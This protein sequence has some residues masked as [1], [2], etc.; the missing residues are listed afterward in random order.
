[1]D[2]RTLSVGG[3]HPPCGSQ[4][5]KDRRL[6]G[7]LRATPLFSGATS[8][9]G[10]RGANNRGVPV[11]RRSAGNVAVVKR[12]RCGWRGQG[13]CNLRNAMCFPMLALADCTLSRPFL[14]TSGARNMVAMMHVVVMVV[15]ISCLYTACRR[16]KGPWQHALRG[17]ARLSGRLLQ[18]GCRRRGRERRRQ[19][20]A[21]HRA[22]LATCRHRGSRQQRCQRHSKDQTVGRPRRNRCLGAGARRSGNICRHF[23]TFGRCATILAVF[24][25][26]RQQVHSR[27]RPVGCAQRLLLAMS[28]VDE[29][30]RAKLGYFKSIELKCFPYDAR[31]RS[32]ARRLRENRARLRPSRCVA[33]AVGPADVEA[34][35]PG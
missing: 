21:R 4:S 27:L 19:R 29:I 3:A 5:D 26:R 11:N 20:G 7:E 28:E 32:R 34:K 16:W 8:D 22:V 25:P 18:Y 35:A 10:A 23:Q 33:D 17:R 31:R 6:A 30:W 9:P 14:A 13:A 12:H 1:M 2:D 15:R 24:N